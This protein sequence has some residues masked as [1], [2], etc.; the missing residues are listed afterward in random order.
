[1]KKEADSFTVSLSGLQ[2]GR[3]MREISAI[4]HP[5]TEDSPRYPLPRNSHLVDTLFP[6]DR[7]RPGRSSC[8]L[9]AKMLYL[10]KVGLFCDGP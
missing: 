10:H 9:Q 7:P 4:S 6:E 8:R 2:N 1:M 5:E 3:E